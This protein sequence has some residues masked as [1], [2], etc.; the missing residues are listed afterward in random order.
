MRIV[1]IFGVPVI[2]ALKVHRLGRQFGDEVHAELLGDFDLDRYQLV[3][4]DE[5][6]RLKVDAGEAAVTLWNSR[7]VRPSEV[8][9]LFVRGVDLGSGSGS[10]SC[11]GKVSS[12]SSPSGPLF[13]ELGRVFVDDECVEAIE[14]QMLKFQRSFRLFV[15]SICGILAMVVGSVV[16]LLFR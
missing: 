7:K 14:V 8:R 11:S 1:L 16:V 5:K 10:G 13:G 15:M 9:W 3:V 4:V 12:P 2:F 6:L